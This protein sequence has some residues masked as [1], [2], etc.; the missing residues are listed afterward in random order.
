MSS[1][2]EQN[3]KPSDEQTLSDEALESVAG[4]A[5]VGHFGPIGG[6]IIAPI[7]ILDPVLPTIGTVLGDTTA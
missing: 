5:S 1:N 4:G 2:S 7:I 6:P 3:V